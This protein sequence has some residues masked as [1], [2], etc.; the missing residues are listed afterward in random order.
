MSRQS[1]GWRGSDRGEGEVMR[2][3][4]SEFGLRCGGSLFQAREIREGAQPVVK[5]VGLA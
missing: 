1:K 4:G 2:E 5:D 3:Y